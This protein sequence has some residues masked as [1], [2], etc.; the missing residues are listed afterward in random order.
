MVCLALLSLVALFRRSEHGMFSLF[1]AY[2]MGS[3]IARW[4]TP[5]LL[6]LPFLRE[7]GRARMVNAELIPEHYATAVLTASMIIVAFACL[8][9]LARQINRMQEEIQHLS[10]RDEL[11]G[12]YNVRGFHLLAEQALRLARRAQQPF[13]VLFVDLDGLKKI[14]DK[15]GHEI[16]SAMI[17]EAAQLLNAVFRETD[18]I[19]RVGGDEFVVAGQFD[20]DAILSAIER[21]QDAVRTANEEE[22]RRFKLSLSIGFAANEGN[23]GETLKSLMTRA[24]A[25]MY[26]V[27]RLK[28]Q[29]AR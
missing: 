5:L 12:V 26:D 4:L 29:T 1:L 27:K 25:V 7:V 20:G 8:I 24:D 18:V 13:C 16:G 23:P 14:N 10:L 17:A 9:F 19:G 11:T 6:V 3:K 2:G 21:V 15:L 28:K 22:G